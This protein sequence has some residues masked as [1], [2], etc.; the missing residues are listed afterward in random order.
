MIAPIQRELNLLSR[1]KAYLSSLCERDLSN[2]SPLLLQHNPVHK[3]VPMLIH[4]GRAVV[5]S[6]VIIEYID[7]TWNLIPKLLQED[8]YERAR[9]TFL[10]WLHPTGNRKI[11][12]EDPGVLD[13]M[14]VA[15]LKDFKAQEKVLGL[16]ILDPEKSPLIYTWVTTLLE[17]ALVKGFIYQAF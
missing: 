15:T 5:E 9:V 14:M 10:D 1:S 12:R 8:P 13:I 17:Q 16:K 11:R 7:K 4:N 3:T 2:K 6:P